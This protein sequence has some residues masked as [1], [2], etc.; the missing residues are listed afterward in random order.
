LRVRLGK[1][2]H[3]LRQVLAIAE[4]AVFIGSSIMG[5]ETVQGDETL[6]F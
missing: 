5:E 3:H 6:I 2:Q 4:G 1:V